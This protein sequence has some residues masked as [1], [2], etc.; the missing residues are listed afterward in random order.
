MKS[1]KST[2]DPSIEFLMIASEQL[3]VPLD[4]LVSSKV[5]ELTPTEEFILNF[6]KSFPVLLKP[7]LIISETLICFF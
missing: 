7:A 6:L 1:G 4:M 2:S 3:E 5:S